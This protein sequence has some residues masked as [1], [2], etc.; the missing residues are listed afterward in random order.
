LRNRQALVL[1]TGYRKLQGVIVQF[2]IIPAQQMQMP[3]YRKVAHI[4]V[5][6]NSG[7]QV[8]DETGDYARLHLLFFQPLHQYLGKL[9]QNAHL[10][11]PAHLWNRLDSLWPQLLFLRAARIMQDYPVF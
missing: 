5:Y 6:Q 10:L 9:A 1:K 2:E 4:W 3:V 11:L 8:S 7:S